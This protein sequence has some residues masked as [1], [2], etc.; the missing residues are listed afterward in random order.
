MAGGLFGP[1]RFQLVTCEV[2]AGMDCETFYAL[3]P[4]LIPK[5][6]ESRTQ[7]CVRLNSWVPGFDPQDSSSWGQEHVFVRPGH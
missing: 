3:I 6:G 2:G 4:A 1:K 5:E 7:T